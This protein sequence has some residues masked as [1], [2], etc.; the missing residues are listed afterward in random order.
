MNEL[1]GKDVYTFYYEGVD[2]SLL[3]IWLRNERMI[4]REREKFSVS[5]LQILRLCRCLVSDADWPEEESVQPWVGGCEREELAVPVEGDEDDGVTGH[6]QQSDV[7]SVRHLC[8][9]FD[10]R[11]G[12]TLYY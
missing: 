1:I 9:G 11:E 4:D 3:K 10:M 2:H 7:E 8:Q 6:V 5:C 12:K